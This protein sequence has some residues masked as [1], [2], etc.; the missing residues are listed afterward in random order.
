MGI[1]GDVNPYYGAFQQP[2]GQL[3]LPGELDATMV[4]VLLGLATDTLSDGASLVN[5]KKLLIH[6]QLSESPQLA[7]PVL[8][9]TTGQAGMSGLFF[10]DAL[11]N[12]VFEELMQA[13]VPANLHVVIQFLQE[14][15]GPGALIDTD[16][17][18]LIQQ[19][20]LPPA[21]CTYECLRGE[22][23]QSAWGIN[24]YL[25][26]ISHTLLTTR[27]IILA[28]VTMSV[29][30]RQNMANAYLNAVD[31]ARERSE[32]VIAQHVE[33]RAKIAEMALISKWIRIVA[34]II[35]II[36]IIIVI[37]L[38]VLFII[39]TLGTGAPIA[40][41]AMIG[42]I[43]AAVVIVAAITALIFMIVDFAMDGKLYSKPLADWAQKTLLPALMFH[44][45]KWG[46]ALEMIPGVSCNKT[47]RKLIA[48]ILM[49]IMIIAVIIILAIIVAATAGSAAGPAIGLAVTL[50]LLI[51]MTIAMTVVSGT[52]LIFDVAYGLAEMA[53]E[54][55]DDALEELFGIRMSS[56]TKKWLTIIFTIIIMI[57]IMLIIIGPALAVGGAGAGGTLAGVAKAL[58]GLAKILQGGVMLGL[59]V[60]GGLAVYQAILALQLA[61]L[62][63]KKGELMADYETIRN[64]L[65]RIFEQ[66]MGSEEKS[67]EHLLS[68]AKFLL[69]S[70]EEI[71]ES[72]STALDQLYQG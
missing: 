59:L 14:V 21:G 63:E 71:I 2:P 3:G 46:D 36:V 16:D 43:I 56:D 26:V 47:I 17:A 22:T 13:F 24:N 25:K 51:F 18:T 11:V 12:Q 39:V 5:T 34:F 42:V 61:A 10:D 55:I 6:R 44:A 40:V 7:E 28:Q 20:H 19:G 29:K 68:L 50:F 69:Q 57:I 8:I 27:R 4:K 64:V 31:L 33:M 52:G 41:A 53:V 38:C 30:E 58:D 45:N 60:Q 32:E 67:T 37:I 23:G 35:A 49:I 66:A 48:L 70:H 62:E 9:A 54:G 15:G 1:S 72:Q 65:M